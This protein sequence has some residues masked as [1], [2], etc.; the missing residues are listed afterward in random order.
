VRGARTGPLSRKRFFYTHVGK[1]SA[2]DAQRLSRIWSRPTCTSCRTCG[3]VGHQRRTH[4]EC[5]GPS[6]GGA[7]LSKS[8]ELTRFKD[9]HVCGCYLAASYR[10][11]RQRADASQPRGAG[12]TRC[13]DPRMSAGRSPSRKAAGF[14]SEP[15][16][17]P[18][19]RDKTDHRHRACVVGRRRP[20]SSSRHQR[21]WS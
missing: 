13:H 11:S 12:A 8:V 2:A 5:T 10:R 3:K 7:A 4:N 20:P 14:R 19:T 1:G 21:K 18:E 17:S 6:N 9:F 16:R 15:G